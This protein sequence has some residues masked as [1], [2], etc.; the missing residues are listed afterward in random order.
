MLLA[1]AVTG[2]G[3]T[4]AAASVWSWYLMP[5]TGPAFGVQSF[6]APFLVSV[7]VAIAVLGLWGVLRRA[8]RAAWAAPVGVL[9]AAAPVVARAAEEASWVV[10]G[11]GGV[12]P[13]SVPYL[14]SQP[15]VTGVIAV[16]AA[17]WLWPTPFPRAAGRTVLLMLAGWA[18]VTGVDAGLAMDGRLWV[19]DPYGTVGV[20]LAVTA[21]LVATTPAPTAVR[22]RLALLPAIP[23]TVLALL[24]DLL[25]AVLSGSSPYWLV[26]EVWRPAVP[27]LC[28][29]SGLA[30]G[31]LL[32]ARPRPRRLVA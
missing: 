2:G 20:A 12:E 1:G 22:W 4:S 17:Q 8:G 9:A 32:T 15:G 21:A 18:V 25:T 3:V 13:W 31:V 28:A 26:D 11:A 10:T 27:A 5:N 19:V 7:A 16:L 24:P 6:L 23:V 29:F 30:A 14:L